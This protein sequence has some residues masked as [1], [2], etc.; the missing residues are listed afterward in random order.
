MDLKKR[1]IRSSEKVMKVIKKS[2]RFLIEFQII[3]AGSSTNLFEKEPKSCSNFKQFSQN[4]FWKNYEKRSRKR[5]INAMSQQDVTQF[6]LFTIE[7][8]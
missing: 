6:F 7:T 1:S 2:E 4:W 8:K 5:K 3:L